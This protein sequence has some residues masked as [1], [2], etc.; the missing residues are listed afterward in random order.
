MTD[1]ER[2]DWLLAPNYERVSDD[3]WDRAARLCPWDYEE[4]S[5]T[6]KWG[7]AAIDEAIQEEAAAKC[8]AIRR[9]GPK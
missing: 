3:I 6:Q 4:S 9:E 2:L 1:T 5:L 7:R 8:N